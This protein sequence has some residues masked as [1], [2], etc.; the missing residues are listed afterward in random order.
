MLLFPSFQVRWYIPARRLACS[1]L[2]AL[3]AA[4]SG[5]R[6]PSRSS[7]IS[8][9]LLN[10]FESARSYWV[11]MERSQVRF[12]TPVLATGGDFSLESIWAVRI[13]DD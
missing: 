4:R 7:P 8:R 6:V 13:E 3:Q 11:W 2:D 12:A 10:S 5:A 1:V 9:L